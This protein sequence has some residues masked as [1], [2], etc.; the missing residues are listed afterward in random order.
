[1]RDKRG[2]LFTLIIH[3][4]IVVFIV[5]FGFTTPLPLPDE[6]GILINFGT[7]EMGS[8]DTEPPLSEIPE[9]ARAENQVSEA[10]DDADISTQD[11]E[12]APSI[13]EE[14]PIRED[15]VEEKQE[16]IT[17][18]AEEETNQEEVEEEKTVNERALYKGRRNTDQESESEGITEGDGNQ[19]SV[20]G[21]TDS[22]NYSQGISTGSG[23]IEFSLSGRNP[24]NLPK[25]KYEYQVEGKVVVQIKVNREGVVTYARAGVKGSDTN[26]QRLLDAAEEAAKKARFDKKPDAAFEQ[27]GTITYYFILQ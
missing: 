2:I 4:V 22:D 8:G 21:S 27:V 25:P 11:F 5:I 14:Q 15:P 9:Q 1:M 16:T 26:D 24:V 13:E 12:E 23:G 20:T 19:G 17:E 3:G 18:Q 7:E 10:D 6:E